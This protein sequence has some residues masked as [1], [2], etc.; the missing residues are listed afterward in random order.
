MANRNIIIVVVIIIIAAGIIFYGYNQSQEQDSQNSN[1]RTVVEGPMIE[2][3]P[4]SYDF[5]IV[6]YGD[7][8]SHTFNIKNLGNEPLEIL[9]LSTSC[10][11]TQADIAET[12]KVIAPGDNVDMTVTFDP[13]VHDDDSD[14]G[15]LTRIIYIKTNDLQNPEIEAEITANVFRAEQF[16]TISVVAKQWSFDPD[17]IRVN[18][19]DVVRL[20]ITSADVSHGFALADFNINETIEPGQ[21]TIIEFIADKK[22]TFGFSCSIPCGRDHGQMRGQLIVE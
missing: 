7:V 9:K 2:V 8:V 11:C 1:F 16:K 13:A 12:D 10:G 3:S 17:P 22:G 20:E 18:Y 15:E 4:L 6:K 19:G 14:L 5:D 21:T